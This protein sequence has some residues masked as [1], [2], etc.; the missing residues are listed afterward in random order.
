MGG[1]FTKAELR[2]QTVGA[3]RQLPKP[4]SNVALG[5]DTQQLAH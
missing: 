1:F 2:E 5:R 4:C 3:T